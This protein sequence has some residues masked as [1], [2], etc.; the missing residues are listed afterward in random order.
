MYVRPGQALTLY[1]QWRNVYYWVQQALPTGDTAVLIIY[2]YNR[3]QL[4]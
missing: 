3:A 4:D 2:I 1:D